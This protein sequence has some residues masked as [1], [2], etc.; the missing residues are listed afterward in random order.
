MWSCGYV[1]YSLGPHPGLLL[2]I[3]LLRLSRLWPLGA[4][5]GS[6]LCTSTHPIVSSV[7]PCFLTVQHFP[8][9]PCIFLAAVLDQPFLQEAL[10]PS[11]WR[12]S[13]KTKIWVLGM[14]HGHR[15]HDLWVLSAD[16][17]VYL[18]TGTHMP[19][20][21]LSLSLNVCTHVK[22]QDFRSPWNLPTPG[23]QH[24]VHSSPSLLLTCNLL[25]QWHTCILSLKIHF[26][27]RLE[28]C[29]FPLWK[30]S[31]LCT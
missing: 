19:A 17:Y 21:M 6:L 11:Y 29:V 9:S 15:D 23:Q 31:I 22:K 8:S 28:A 2:F 25:W 16:K 26:R 3:L 1:F 18:S 27:P 4:P 12:M 7:L 13:L 5:S 14:L 10:V 30:G 20:F 24:R